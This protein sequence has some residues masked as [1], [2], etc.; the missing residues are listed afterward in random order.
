MKKTLAL[1]I[2]IVMALGCMS[3]TAFAENNASVITATL[4][5]MSYT[6]IIP[7]ETTLTE[8]AHADILMGGAS[9]KASITVDA[10]GSEKETVYYTVDLAKADLS[11]GDGHTIS[12]SY[13]YAQ[14]EEYAALTKDTKVTVYTDGKVVDSTLKVTADNTEWMAAPSGDYTATV[15]FN[16]AKED[17]VLK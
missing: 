7:S 15:V 3:I 1:V 14:D 13:T 8:D 6:I 4:P 12:T 16:F 2:A 17:V 11:D 5:K 9:G 10:H